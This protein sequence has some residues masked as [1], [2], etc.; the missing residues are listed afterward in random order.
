LI[1]GSSVPMIG[2]SG[3]VAG[4]LGAYLVFYSDARVLTLIP[5]F[6]VFTTAWIPAFFFIP[7]WFLIQLFSGTAQVVQGVGAEAGVAFW[8]HI[9]GF[10]AGYITAQFYKKK[11]KILRKYRV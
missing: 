4:I 10:V 2:A 11:I 5:I 9:G 8:A 7:Y 1:A 3:A 6:I